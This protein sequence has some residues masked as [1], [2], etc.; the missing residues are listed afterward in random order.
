[1]L[2]YI[3]S[4]AQ[5]F[6][7]EHGEAPDVVYINP[8]HFEALFRAYPRLFEPDQE[9]RLGFKLVILPS[10]ELPH[11]QASLQAQTSAVRRRHTHTGNDAYGA[12]E[13][14]SIVA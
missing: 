7:R 12:D 2:D 11:P 8:V 10:S 3:L 1:M 9:I 5:Q 4:Q 6:E 13:V 14:L